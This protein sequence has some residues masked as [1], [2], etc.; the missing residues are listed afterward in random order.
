[1]PTCHG[2]L[3]WLP[4]DASRTVFFLL[5]KWL[6]GLAMVP[7]GP[8]EVTNEAL[9]PYCAL[10]YLVPENRCAPAELC[11]K[12][13]S[14][15]STA[16]ANLPVVS[17]DRCSVPR[18]MSTKEMPKGLHAMSHRCDSSD[19]LQPLQAARAPSKGCRHL[20]SPQPTR[21]TLE[22]CRCARESRP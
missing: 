22:I 13:K 5:T 3:H 1:L 10:R 16:M 21:G 12:T 8:G 2:P 7:P 4:T 19:I 15:C 18:A 14:A 6:P 9:L 11:S 20:R 17:I